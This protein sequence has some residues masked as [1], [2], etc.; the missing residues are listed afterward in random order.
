MLVKCAMQSAFAILAQYLCLDVCRYSSSPTD[1]A[2]KWC[3]FVWPTSWGG[4]LLLTNVPHYCAT[5][6]QYCATAPHYYLRLLSHNDLTL[7]KQHNFC[8]WLEDSR[9]LIQYSRAL[10]GSYTCETLKFDLRLVLVVR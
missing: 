3:T 6:P 1:A 7:A 9:I 10:Q 8:Q 5:A 2:S 4:K